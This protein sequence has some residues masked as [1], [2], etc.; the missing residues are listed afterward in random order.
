MVAHLATKMVAH[1][2]TK[3]VAHLATKMVAFPQDIEKIP[4]LPG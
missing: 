1:L 4:L 3:M 2:A